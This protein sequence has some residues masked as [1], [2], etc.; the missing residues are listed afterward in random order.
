MKRTLITLLAFIPTIA[1]AHG[2]NILVFMSFELALIFGIFIF[3]LF[4][5][6]SKL[7]KF[8]VVLVYA[9]STAIVWVATE[10]KAYPHNIALIN[11]VTFLLP[12]IFSSITWF[13]YVKF[14]KT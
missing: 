4:S 8:L 7:C 12:A 9:I 13:L 11:V 1:Y 6:S 14:Q 10:S 5:K 3:L 2:E